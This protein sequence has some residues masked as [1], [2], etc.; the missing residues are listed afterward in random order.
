M[1]KAEYFRTLFYRVTSFDSREG[2][3]DERVQA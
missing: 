3:K 2:I 1:K